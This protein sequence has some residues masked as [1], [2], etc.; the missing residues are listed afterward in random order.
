MTSSIGGIL[1]TSSVRHIFIMVEDLAKMTNF[2]RDLLGLEVSHS[3][4]EHCTFFKTGNEGPCIVLHSGRESSQRGAN[5]WFI[6]LGVKGI[7]EVVKDLK[8]K[9]VNVGEIKEHPY[10]KVAQF[11]DP[12]ENCLE[13]HEEPKG[14]S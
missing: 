1:S 8:S 12:E 4:E 11:T 10:G 6:V 2:Y 9:G 13:V 3:E 14:R 5:H 7:E